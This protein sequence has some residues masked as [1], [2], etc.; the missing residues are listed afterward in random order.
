MTFL[1]IFIRYSYRD[2][3][4]DDTYDDD[5]EDDDDPL[6]HTFEILFGSSRS[7]CQNVIC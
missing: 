4:H 5:E 6:K 1:F 3:D 7:P 2:R